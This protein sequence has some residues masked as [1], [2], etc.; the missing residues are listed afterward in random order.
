MG[1]NRCYLNFNELKPHSPTHLEWRSKLGKF[2][3]RPLPLSVDHAN[4][5]PLQVYLLH[6]AQ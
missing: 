6:R 5:S 3:L 2:A 1:W 4:E